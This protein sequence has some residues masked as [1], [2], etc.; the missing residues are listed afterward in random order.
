MFNNVKDIDHRH[1]Q[2]EFM[3]RHSQNDHRHYY[4]HQMAPL[5]CRQSNPT[6]KV[7]HDNITVSVGSDMKHLF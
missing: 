7:N 4:V 1:V 6:S 5:F 2:L 3:L